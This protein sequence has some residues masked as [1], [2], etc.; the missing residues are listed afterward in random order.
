MRFGAKGPSA[1]DISKARDLH[2]R[3]RMGE[4][5]LAYAAILE[6]DPGQTD[7]LHHLGL[8]KKEQGRKVEAHRLL[9][10]ALARCSRASESVA[11]TPDIHIKR[12]D[13]LY[14]LE[15]Y[16]EAVASYDRALSL[17]PSSAGCLI[18]RG[19]SLY[20]INR[21]EASLASYERALALA[22][23]DATILIYRA[24]SL[25]QLGRCEEALADVDQ[26]L[27]QQPDFASVYSLR[28]EILA[29]LTRYDEAVAQFEL[30][31]RHDPKFFPARWNIAV[32][33]LLHGDFRRGW[34]DYECRWSSP[35]A[36]RR[37]FRSPLWLGEEP[38]SGKT[39]L[40]HAEQGFGDT[41][42]FARYAPLAAARGA[43][44]ILEVQA[45]L[46]TLMSRM[47][48]VA[49]VLSQPPEQTAESR[50]DGIPVPLAGEQDLPPFDFHC[51]LLSLPLAFKTELDTVPAHIP[52]LRADP[53]LAARWRARLPEA[54]SRRVGLAWWG[55]P[56]HWR[57]RNRSIGLHR[58]AP[59]LSEPFEFVSLQKAVSEADAK[60]IAGV[61]NLVHFGDELVDFDQTAAL[62]AALDLIVT[63]DTAV[64]H[65]A[66][67][68]GKPVWILLPHTPEWRWLLDRE[69][70][71]W[72]PNV[73]LFRQKR[74]D[75]WES[76]IER[77]RGSL[78]A[79]VPAAQDRR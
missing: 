76:V 51:P 1:G 63:V 59:L 67:A 53:E 11:D 29:S 70:T 22:P 57:D 38:L 65:L 69:D 46:K 49:T 60:V 15:R 2:K 8:I 52:Y 77:V 23:G 75:D 40:L 34:R 47:E 33:R 37:H 68:M 39:I 72:Y 78:S 21:Y 27:T 4:A 61:P 13:I 41:I 30:A 31:L 50:I 9:T 10:A 54:H 26:A 64:A 24:R 6:R 14:G 71:P 45:E 36:E 43:T 28:G 66:A 44:V 42:Q 48:R 19:L 58:L 12:G 16:F 17:A 56:F 25:Y 62:L 74:R 18:K 55:N 7:A 32:S 20:Q 35:S 79:W 73:R 3:G 5:E